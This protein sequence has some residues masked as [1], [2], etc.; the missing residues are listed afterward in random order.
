MKHT[1]KPLKLSK[2]LSPAVVESAKPEAE[3]YR[4]WDTTVPQLFLRVQPSGVKSWNV[5]WSRLSSRSLGK[6][7]GCTVESARIKAKAALVETD[8]HGAPLAIIEANKPA[9]PAI[10]TLAAFIDDHYEAWALTNQKRGKETI[11]TLRA[12]HADLLPKRLDEL[13]AFDFERHKSARIKSGVT[14][15]TVNR[16]LSRIR[17]ALSRAIEWGMLAQHPMKRVKP[18]KG[19]DDG[20]VRY[21]RPDEEKRLRDALQAREDARR[22]ARESGNDWSRQRGENVRPLWP[23][24][25]FTDHLMPM[26]LAAL[27]TGMR[28]GE[29]LALT[30]ENVSLERKTLTVVA[31]SAKS[32]RT[33]HIPLNA[34]AL[35][36]LKRWKKH[37]KGAGYV[38]ASAEGERMAT[39]TTSWRK[40]VAAAKLVDFRFHDLRH[41]F[42][43]HLVMGGVDLYTVMRLLGHADFEMT[44]KYAH[45]A[46]DHLSAAVAVLGQKR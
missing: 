9:D 11:D 33:R 6:W 3:P 36:I 28:R 29:L 22:A 38:F 43:S 5:Q 25:G 14:P 17:G 40:V 31:A 39:V 35:D 8:Q 1:K 4:V 30:W 26:V 13:S 23:D 21:L 15:A 24:D 16:D 2:K 34:E 7:P 32:G 10:L 19:D 12:V 42:A 46:P 45:L 37:T 44:Q 18:L 20:R 27:N 41:T